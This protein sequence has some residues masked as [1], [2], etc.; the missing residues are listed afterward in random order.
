MKRIRY[1]VKKSAVALL[2]LLLPCS[3]MAAPIVV[4]I[5]DVPNAQ[6]VIHVLGAPN[7]YLIYT[8]ELVNDPAIEEGAL[9][10]LYDANNIVSDPDAALSDWGG[11]FVDPTPWQALPPLYLL[12]PWDPN[13]NYRQFRTAV[14]IVWVEHNFYVPE[15]YPN[16]GDLI[17]GFNSALPGNWYGNPRPGGDDNLGP[18]TD[19]W[20]TVY[21]NDTVVIRYK[22]HTYVAKGYVPFNG[23]LE[24][25]GGPAT[26]PPEPIPDNPNAFMREYNGSG[27]ANQ[28]SSMKAWMKLTVYPDQMY[29]YTDPRG[30][31]GLALPYSGSAVLTAANGNT[32]NCLVNGIEGIVD[33]PSPVPW[34]LE[35]DLQVT[36]GTG[37]FDGARG[38]VTF[39]GLEADTITADFEGVITSVGKNK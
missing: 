22:P 6:P 31:E 20:V 33:A 29:P 17:V 7:G 39:T 36:S 38:Y 2:T 24:L 19:Q 37:R 21:A 23:S 1:A 5:N 10:L 8:G 15:G 13:V 11:R 26:D 12:P 14:D 28:L 18:V 27:L 30:Y 25:V 34:W 35:G 3:L 4:S 32:I 9:I 16:Y